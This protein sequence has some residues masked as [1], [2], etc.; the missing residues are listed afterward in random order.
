MNKVGVIRSN[1][2][3]EVFQKVRLPLDPVENSSEKNAILI[4]FT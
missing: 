2:F 3:G 4:L 1:R